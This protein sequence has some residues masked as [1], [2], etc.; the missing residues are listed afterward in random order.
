MFDLE[1]VEGAT[2]FADYVRSVMGINQHI[3]VEK[4]ISKYIYPD[5]IDT[6]NKLGIVEGKY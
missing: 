3:S 4:L 6:F 5:N 2:E 1:R